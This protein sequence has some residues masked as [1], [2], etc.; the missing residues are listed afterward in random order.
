MAGAREL[1]AKRTIM[2]I[3]RDGHFNKPRSQEAADMVMPCSLMVSNYFVPEASF[4]P[5]WD[6]AAWDSAISCSAAG[7]HTSGGMRTPICGSMYIRG[8]G[9]PCW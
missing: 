4:L 5:E 6:T 1:R 7:E 2:K 9:A 3:Y 8:K